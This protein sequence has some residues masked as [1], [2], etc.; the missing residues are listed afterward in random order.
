MGIFEPT[1][2]DIYNGPIPTDNV[3]LKT[4]TKH[5]LL[6]VGDANNIHMCNSF[7]AWAKFQ[8]SNT[9]QLIKFPKKIWIQTK[10]IA[11]TFFTIICTIDK[12]FAY[13]LHY[14]IQKK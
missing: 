11:Y 8:L 4:S 5:F 12:K 3:N 14:I 9:T 7:P 10:Q 2:R 1:S 13:I 6:H